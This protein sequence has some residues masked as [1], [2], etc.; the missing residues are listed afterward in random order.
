MRKRARDCS[1]KP[2]QNDGINSAKSRTVLCRTTR[3]AWQ[4]WNEKPG[5]LAFRLAMPPNYK[6]VVHPV[7]NLS[8]LSLNLILPYQ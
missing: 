3:R 6:T 4:A 8:K 7:S 1:G 2:L 5:G